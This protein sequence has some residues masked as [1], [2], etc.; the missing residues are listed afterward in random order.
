[1]LT[2]V[3]RHAVER[4]CERYYGISDLEDKS[5]YKMIGDAMIRELILQYPEASD[6]QS[7]KYYVDA[8]DM[9]FVLR[10]GTIA[11]VIPKN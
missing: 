11:T 3:T 9:Y 2:S 4:L 10:D 6:I 8:Y 1:M 5:R 7:G